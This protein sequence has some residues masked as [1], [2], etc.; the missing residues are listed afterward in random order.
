M[1]LLL[2]TDGTPGALTAVDLVAGARWPSDLV[3]DV[4]AVVDASAPSA[5]AF[6]PVPVV[7]GYDEERTA[8]ALATAREAAARLGRHGI[9]A[10]ARVIHGREADAIV[11]RAIETETS[12]IVCGSRGH[13]PLRA[14]LLDRCQRRWSSELTA[15]SSSPATPRSAVS[16]SRPTARH[17]RSR[18]S[19]WSCG[20]RSSRR[21]PSMS[22][23]SP[24][25][26]P[27]LTTPMPASCG[28]S[29]SSSTRPRNDSAG[30]AARHARS[31]HGYPAHEI[32]ES[33]Q[34]S[35]TDSSSWAPM[36]GRAST[37]CSSAAWPGMSSPTAMHRCSSRVS[38]W[39]SR[40]VGVAPGCASSRS[41]DPPPVPRVR[42][43]LATDGSVGA[44][45]AIDLVT[46]LP[47]PVGTEVE[48]L[49]VIDTGAVL[50]MPLMAVP[51]DTTALSDAVRDTEREGA[52]AAVALLEDH[53]LIREHDAVD[54]PTCRCHRA[55]SDGHPGGPRRVWQSRPRPTRGAA[56]RLRLRRGLRPGAVPGA[57]GSSR[58]CHAHPPGA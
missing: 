18:P 5:F 38:R 30:A 48:V 6:A 26:W 39:H 4:V 8:N 22:S 14:R 36:A 29:W 53:G 7:H 23:P 37:G 34:R 17:R 58:P 40:N 24:T 3:V 43:I 21:V 12:L 49:A 52:A 51:G 45:V 54:G 50:P 44:R 47:W 32:V 56:A 57:R 28:T 2:A 20:C 13:G 35:R 33:A 42:L 25:C 16:P 10:S 41:L 55:P 15:P 31:A 11:Q 1:R 27:T 46:A 19:I 9:I